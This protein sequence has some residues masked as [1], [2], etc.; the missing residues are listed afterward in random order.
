[1]CWLLN[2]ALP[3]EACDR[4]AAFR[5]RDGFTV[6]HC[7]DERTVTLF[8]AGWGVFEVT[9]GGGCACGLYESPQDATPDDD[10]VDKLKKMR[11]R[12]AHKGW[13]AAKIERAVEAAVSAQAH[14]PAHSD[15][16]RAFRERVCNWVSE[17]GQICLLAYWDDRDKDL[18][19]GGW[20]ELD[21]DEML[22]RGF[23]PSTLV[24][25]VATQKRR[26]YGA[27]LAK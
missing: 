10:A 5:E 22:Q 13:S 15:H 2:F 23:P 20:L 12:Y 26:C 17:F 7:V 25:V 16:A 27:G 9:F 19:S 21:V 24:H 3:P 1:M 18:A 4:F 6:A 11:L 8:P 14:K